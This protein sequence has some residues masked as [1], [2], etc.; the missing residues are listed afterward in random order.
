MIS[1]RRIC[2]FATEDEDR[3]VTVHGY[4]DTDSIDRF[5]TD[6][7]K[8]ICFDDC[9]NESVIEIIWR[10]K[11][12]YYAGWHPGMLYTFYNSNRQVVW[13]GSFPEWDH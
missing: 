5:F 11:E 6:I 13:E 10:G 4:S 8:T 2:F 1:D 12:V 7:S 3:H 9:T